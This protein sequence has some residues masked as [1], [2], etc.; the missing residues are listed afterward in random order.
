MVA[1]QEKKIERLLEC[2][3]NIIIKGDFNSLVRK[4]VVARKYKISYTYKVWVN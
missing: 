3:S 1:K 4:L 2:N